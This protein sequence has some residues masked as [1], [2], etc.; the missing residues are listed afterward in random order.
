MGTGFPFRRKELLPRYLRAFEGALAAFED[1]RRPGAAALDLAWVAAGV[2][3]GFFELA[4]APWDV[5]AG[6][7]LISGG[8]R[9]RHRLG[10]RRRM[11][12]RRHR[13]RGPGVHAQLL[14][15][16]RPIELVTVLDRLLEPQS[17]AAGPV[18]SG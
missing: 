14:G 5:A 11:A 16:D 3:D 2:F 6:G 17:L 12:G 7:L 8:G 18:G 13:G 15:L 9:R 10:R 1:L 4:L